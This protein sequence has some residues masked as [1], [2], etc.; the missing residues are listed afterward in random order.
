MIITKIYIEENSKEYDIIIGKNRF[1][2]DE[3]IKSAN[4]EDIWF[5]LEDF[6]GPHIIIN[7]NGDK[8]TKKYL[9]IIASLFPNY[10]NNLPKSYN[11]IYTTINNIKL[12]NISGTVITSNTKRIKIS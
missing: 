8:I 4:S 7:N 6:S 9:F 3:I 11:V 12:T 2:N 10:K 1:E 5:H